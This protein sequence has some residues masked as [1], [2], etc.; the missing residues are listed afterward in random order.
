METTHQIFSKEVP[1]DELK[2]INVTLLIQLRGKMKSL[3]MGATGIWDM[4]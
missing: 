2:N 4:H 1:I 3:Q